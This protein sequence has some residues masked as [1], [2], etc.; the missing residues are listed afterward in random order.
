MKRKIVFLLL[1]ILLISSPLCPEEIRLGDAVQ[2]ALAVN[3]GLKSNKHEVARLTLQKKEAFTQ[4]LPR[5]NFKASYT[6]LDNPIDLELESLR[7]LI[8]K[9]ETG[10]QLADINLQN[11]LL[12]G[13]PLSAMEKSAYAAGITSTLEGLIPSFNIHVLD[14]N[15]QR[16]SLEATLPIW[17]GGKIQ[18]LNKAARLN[19][20]EGQTNLELTAEQVRA[21]TTEIYMLNK[22][23]EEVVSLYKEA[24]IGIQDH[25][26]KAESLFNAGLIAKYQV[27]RAKVALSDAQANRQKAEENLKTARSLLGNMLNIENI[28]TITLTTPLTYEKITEDKTTLWNWVKESNG[29]LKKMAIKKELVTVK[30]RGDLGDYLPQIYAFGKYELTTKDLSLL[31]PKWAVGVGVNFNLFSSGEKYFKLKADNQLIAEVS[32]K[33]LEVEDMLKKLTDKLYYSAT[34]ELHCIDTFE[35]RREEA[36]ENLKLAESRFSSGLG[37]SLE[38]VDANLLLLKI[39]VERLQAIYNYTTLWLQINRLGQN[40]EKSIHTLEGTK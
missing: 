15:I 13:V 35:N 38:V 32:E 3:H 40:L 2:K 8:I 19:L 16:A 36:T 25:K 7:Q 6:H 5:V 22:L 28:D 9:L 27:L 29:I 20:K 34:A 39:N 10:G 37:I 26:N 17:I 24:E 30:K 23:L 4:Y 12:K 14:Q 31:D 11:L 1:I 21:D 18:A 33:A